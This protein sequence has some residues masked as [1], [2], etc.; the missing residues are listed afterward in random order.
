[1]SVSSSADTAL[2]VSHS[3]QRASNEKSSALA[4]IGELFSN[5]CM[6]QVNFIYHIEIIDACCN[7]LGIN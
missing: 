1:M 7:I 3:K 6:F 4:A 5:F 2:A